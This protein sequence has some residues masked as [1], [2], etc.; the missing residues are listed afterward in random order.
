MFG[1][2]LPK[3]MQISQCSWQIPGFQ[4]TN[5]RCQE[6]CTP[7]APLVD[8]SG[9]HWQHCLRVHA[10]P[11]R[12]VPSCAIWSWDWVS[13]GASWWC[14]SFHPALTAKT[15]RN[16]LVAGDA[17]MPYPVEILQLHF[18]KDPTRLTIFPCP[19][20]SPRLGDTMWWLTCRFRTCPSP[21]KAE[22]PTNRATQQP[23]NEILPSLFPVR[24]FIGFLLQL[25][26]PVSHSVDS[27][28]RNYVGLL[29]YDIYKDAC[30]ERVCRFWVCRFWT[31]L[32]IQ[33]ENHIKSHH[34]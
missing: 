11:C 29:D 20:G 8:R 7:E 17:L 1:G 31:K 28:L 4:S 6:N 2:I 16:R 23:V 24:A 9:H 21:T 25:S 26:G 12:M 32:M 18:H 15:A 34:I 22:R 30:R 19:S 14:L 13:A 5:K 10:M 27:P 3:I 33:T